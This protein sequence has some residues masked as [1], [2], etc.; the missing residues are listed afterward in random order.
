MAD[1]IDLF[2][3]EVIDERKNRLHGEVVLKQTVSSKM[4]VTALIAIILIAA[5]WV[6]FGEYAR[7]EQARGILVTTE[8]SAKILATRAGVITDLK[9]SEGDRVEKGSIIAIINLESRNSDGIAG[10]A[11]VLGTLDTRKDLS[12]QQIAIMETRAI[13]EKSRLNKQIVST[14][15]QI[16]D[17]E[18]QIGFQRDIVE[19]NQKL[20]EKIEVV[21]AR[22]F[23][24]QVDYEARRQNLLSSKQ[25][26]SRL[27]QQLISLEGE[28]GRARSEI[29]QIALNTSQ[30]VSS[31]NSSI[32]TLTQQQAQT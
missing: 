10:A 17:V 8:P 31:M 25:A 2:R 26:L 23:V 12:R 29:S 32:E 13:G 11:T 15:N 3:Q 19:S 6:V 7:T 20:F 4:M 21:V 1:S 22:G 28:I 16:K 27:E 24:S 18:A 30:E 9:V 5:V 14:S